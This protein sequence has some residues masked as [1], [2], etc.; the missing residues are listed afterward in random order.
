MKKNTRLIQKQK[1]TS[2]LSKKND[3]VEYNVLYP[4]D[5]ETRSKG[6]TKEKVVI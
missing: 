3:N 4:S 1:K 2:K 6:N 5:E